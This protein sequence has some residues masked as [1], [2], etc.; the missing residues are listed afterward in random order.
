VGWEAR[1]A[2][3]VVALKRLILT[4]DR[5]AWLYKRVLFEY[6]DNPAEWLK[7]V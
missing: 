2:D 6:M 5:V 4:G 1:V 7:L 3:A